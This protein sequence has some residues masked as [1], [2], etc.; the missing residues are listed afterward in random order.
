[1]IN[2]CYTILKDILDGKK[3]YGDQ[4]E[5]DTNLK[6]YFRRLIKDEARYNLDMLNVIQLALASSLTEQANVALKCLSINSSDLLSNMSI[7][8]SSIFEGEIL[9]AKESEII[10]DAYD[11]D[12][13][14]KNNSPLYSYNFSYRKMKVLRELARADFKT[15]EVLSLEVRCKNI[16]RELRNLLIKIES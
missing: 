9:S 13:S 2:F 14:R 5:K 4:V 6:R 10:S 11:K 15:A 12:L 16:N 8:P 7:S 3:V 1:M